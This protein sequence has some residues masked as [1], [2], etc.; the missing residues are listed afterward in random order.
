MYLLICENYK[1]LTEGFKENY[2]VNN[3]YNCIGINLDFTCLSIN[4]LLKLVDYYNIIKEK[5]EYIL[6][7]KKTTI[8]SLI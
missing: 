3:M 2:E 5:K 7:I 6:D 4:Q 8:I 1:I